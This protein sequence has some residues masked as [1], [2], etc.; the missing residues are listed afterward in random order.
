MEIENTLTFSKVKMEFSMPFFIPMLTAKDSLDRVFFRFG[1]VKCDC[2]E[3]G[4]VKEIPA[5]FMIN[6]VGHSQL[7]DSLDATLNTKDQ[8]EIRCAL[9][10]RI[11]KVLALTR[12][13]RVKEPKNG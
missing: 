5:R 12:K 11:I 8:C 6:D 13:F 3:T 7:D 2:I 1:E 10:N 4:L 9:C